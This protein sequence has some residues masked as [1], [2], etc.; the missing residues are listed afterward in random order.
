MIVNW[1]ENYYRMWYLAKLTIPMPKIHE[2][3]YLSLHKDLEKGH[4]ELGEI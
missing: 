3:V 2:K 4:Q 1:N